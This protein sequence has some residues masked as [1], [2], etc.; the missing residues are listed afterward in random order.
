MITGLLLKSVVNNNGEIVGNKHE[1]DVVMVPGHSN[2]VSS[3]NF[4]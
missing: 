2:D 3:S 4:C 1:N